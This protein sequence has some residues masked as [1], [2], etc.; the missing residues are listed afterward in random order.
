MN[1]WSKHWHTA[2]IC[3]SCQLLRAFPAVLVKVSTR[4]KLSHVDV[5][6]NFLQHVP[7]L[8]RFFLLL[9]YCRNSH[10][11]S[12]PYSVLYSHFVSF[13]S[14]LRKPIDGIGLGLYIAINL[15]VFLQFSLLL[16]RHSLCLALC[17]FFLCLFELLFPLPPLA[18][19]FVLLLFSFFSSCCFTVSFV[20]FS[21][22]TIFPFL[23]LFLLFFYFLFS[24]LSFYFISL[25][26]S[27]FYPSSSSFPFHASISSSPLTCLV[28]DQI[29]A[30]LVPKFSSS[31]IK[32]LDRV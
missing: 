3:G 5:H 2:I 1:A 4:R 23:V 26:S 15:A 21:I 28:D 20:F 13:F 22:S 7:L 8:S 30:L 19:S 17:L 31:L 27:Y 16:S 9:V 29:L 32:L 14:S 11:C 6:R 10:P 25:T 12:A 24:F 18:L